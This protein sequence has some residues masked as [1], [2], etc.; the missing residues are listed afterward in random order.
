MADIMNM[1]GWSRQSTFERFYY[2]SIQNDNYARTV[3][4]TS[5][6]YN[7]SF[8]HTLSYAKPALPRCGINSLTRI[9]R[10]WCEIGIP[11]VA[12]W[13]YDSVP[14]LDKGSAYPDHIYMALIL[15]TFISVQSKRLREY[16]QEQ[17][18]GHA[19]TCAK[20]YIDVQSHCSN[21][22]F[23][24]HPI[25]ATVISQNLRLPISR[26]WSPFAHA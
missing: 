25:W 5:T 4:T 24:S 11:R 19:F 18:F 6:Q 9:W 20:L 8:N 23:N 13:V 12:G 26:G 1:A 16:L 15:W 7:K 21:S 2:K 10:I 17:T 3:L 14:P 22:S